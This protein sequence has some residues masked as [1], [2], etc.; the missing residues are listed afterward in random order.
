VG[1]VPFGKPAPHRDP[2]YLVNSYGASPGVTSTFEKSGNLKL[3]LFF[4]R[5]MC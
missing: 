1:E 5:V 4:Q 2:V 3:V